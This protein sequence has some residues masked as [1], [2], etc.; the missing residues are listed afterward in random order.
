MS[1]V[2][3]RRGTRGCS[4]RMTTSARSPLSRQYSCAWS[5]CRA[6]GT[7]SGPRAWTKQDRQV[8]RDAEPPESGLAELIASG[9]L[10]GGAK[11][12]VGEEDAR[13][14]PLEQQRVVTRDR[15]VVQRALGVTERRARR[16]ACAALGSRYFCASAC[17]A[18]R[19]PA[20]PVANDRR[21]AAPGA[22][23]MRW[24]RLKIGSST[25]PSVPESR[26]PSI[27]DGRARVAAASEKLRAVGFP[28]NRSLRPSFEAQRR[29]APRASGSAGSRGRRWQ[30][31]A[32]LAGTYSVSTNSLPKAGC[33]R[34]AAGSASAIST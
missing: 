24:R 3:D 23:R 16:R 25:T 19:S 28:F 9:R 12:S 4:L 14:Q 26:R 27:A 31:N 32:E 18:S 33:A 1:C 7:A 20:T 6:S 5:T 10:T 15:Q 2:C 34:S 21:T 30:S 22:S 8:A 13:G 17:A 11:R 29:A